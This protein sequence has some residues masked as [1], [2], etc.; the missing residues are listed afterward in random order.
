[1]MMWKVT[2]VYALGLIL[3]GVGTYLGTGMVSWT[4]LIPSIIGVLFVILG[5][6]AMK[7]N[8]RKHVMHAAAMLALIT[9][10]ATFSG[11]TQTI[12]RFSGVEIARPQAAFAKAAACVLTIAFL[13]MCIRSFI[14]ARRSRTMGE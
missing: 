7:D 1:M 4:A 14:A 8:L 2:L 5:F 3:L 10:I 6:L 11:I 13:G 12:Q 9:I